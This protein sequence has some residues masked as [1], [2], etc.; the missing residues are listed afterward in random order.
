MLFTNGENNA[1]SILSIYTEKDSVFILA[2][3]IDTISRFRF[4]GLPG[5]TYRLGIGHSTA[6]TKLLPGIYTITGNTDS[7]LVEVPV[8]SLGE[9][10]VSSKKSFLQ[11]ESDRLVINP[12]ASSLT[13]GISLMEMLP[14][15][16]GVNVL[17]GNM[18]TVNGTPDVLL[19]I[20]GKSYKSSSAQALQLLSS[21]RSDNI[22]KIEIYTTPPARFD[23]EGSSVINIVLKK[24]KL[25]STVNLAY[26]QRI[27]PLA[28]KAGTKLN[29][30]TGGGNFYYSIGRLR[31]NTR[32]N[33]SDNSSSFTE[34]RSHT[35]FFK[36]VRIN[37]STIRSDAQNLLISL[38]ANYSSGR[39]TFGLS[40]TGSH[41]L[42][43]KIR[44]LTRDEFLNS[45]GTTDSSFVSDIRTDVRNNSP[46][47]ILSYDNLLNK[48]KNEI[49]S[50][51]VVAGTYTNQYDIAREVVRTHPAASAA[52]QQWQDFSVRSGALR[53][54]YTKTMTRIGTFETGFKWTQVRNGDNY[55]YTDG[56]QTLFAFRES[57][58]ALYVNLAK[59]NPQ[60]LSYTAG[61]R[62]EQTLNTALSSLAA[63][64]RI[65]R[66]Y[67][68][69][70]PS[71]SL[72][73]PAGKKGKTGLS[74]SRRIA[75]PSYNNFNP[76]NFITFN[77]AF[78][79][80]EGNLALRPQYLSKAE[81]FYQLGS[82]Y[83]AATYTRRTNVR[84]LLAEADDD[85]F[86]RYK[87][88]NI[89]GTDLNLLAA[90]GHKIRKAWEASF[91]VAGQYYH[92]TLPDRSRVNNIACRMTA[93]QAFTFS[94]RF[95][96]SLAV[97]YYS[98]LRMNYYSS[99]AYYTIDLGLTHTLLNDK[100]TVDLSVNDL[101][102]SVK[103]GSVYY[104]PAFVKRVTPLT[105][106]RRL[107]LNISY[108]FRTATKFQLK[109]KQ[110]D[111]FG[112]NRFYN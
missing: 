86:I 47:A 3:N 15:L 102:G 71:F 46:V 52:D 70:F 79:T 65:K 74:Y 9:I 22:E 38:T 88:I 50:I 48:A 24:D 68:D 82:F 103:V 59:S 89:T 19:V 67:I 4:T 37:E 1:G 76:A 10:I 94:P 78:A 5:G 73:Y 111:E 81:A 42:G 51:A 87:T 29:Q 85:H 110:A 99:R 30:L 75:R 2:T 93:S 90:Y 62:V 91:D 21:L 61:L 55:T 13:R 107:S 92:Y 95:R 100:V 106:E 56:G 57:I 58:Q 33:F 97:R 26:A 16:P 18:I 39:H 69:L 77:D 25:L 104:Y 96:S 63:A 64:P 12:D 44:S 17:S 27:Y 72:Q 43:I 112:E 54:N 45:G 40:Y 41:T 83:T 7:L 35:Q 31:L 66:V 14:R 84:T 20:D 8:K 80:Q 98:P 108:R 6:T 101:T 11:R 60:R 32:I 34:E 53:I 109:R 23:A 105:N 49:F 28:G 36:G